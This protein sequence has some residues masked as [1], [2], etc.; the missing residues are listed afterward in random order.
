MPLS[1]QDIDHLEAILFD[2]AWA[3]ET[4]DYFGL[5]GAVSA[6]VVGP[7]KVTEEQLLDLTFA[8]ASDKLTADHKDHFLRCIAHIETEL[9]QHLHEG[10]SIRLPHEDEEAF[11]QCL[12]SW[13]AGFMEAFFINEK[14]WFQKDEEIAAELLLPYMA[15]SGLFDHEEFA[16]IHSNDHL[17]SQFE[18]IA[19]EQLTDIYLYY[20]AN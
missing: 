19:P 6:S 10:T 8:D 2:E 15:L 16:Q 9:L 13:C 14:T 11:E 4:L 7:K 17:M 3:D 20:H 18:T 1:D 12:E 5:H